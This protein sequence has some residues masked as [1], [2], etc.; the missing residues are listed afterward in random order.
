MKILFSIPI[1]E[2][3]DVV[4]NIVDNIKKFVKDPIII[5]HAN[6]IF[7]DFDASRFD[8]YSNVYVNSNRFEF[9]KYHSLLPIL[10]TNYYETSHL[11][12]DYH[13]FFYSNEMFIKPGIEDYIAGK[14]C[15]FENV[16]SPTASDR[17]REMFAAC[18]IPDYFQ[19]QPF[20]NNHIEGTLYSKQLIDKIFA[21]VSQHLMA[22]LTSKTSIEE[23]VIPTLAYMY[24][25]PDERIDAYNHFQDWDRE[26]SLNQLEFLLTPGQPCF[27]G[28]TAN[29]RS[30]TTDTIFTIKPVHRTLNS[31]LRQMINQL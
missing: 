2:N 9:T 22:L 5:F 27:I 4:I 25:S 24:T 21:F 30:G 7:K 3:M 18:D 20:I 1:H 17:H 26:V 14:Q 13:C 19:G 31:Q 10:M 16:F 11:E 28:H 8:I 12:Y 6:P 29:E 15:V 23:T